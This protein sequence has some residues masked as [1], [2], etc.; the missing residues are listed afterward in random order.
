MKTQCILFLIIFL[1][2]NIAYSISLSQIKNENNNIEVT[3]K[4]TSKYEVEVNSPKPK[5]TN[6]HKENKENIDPK[7]IEISKPITEIQANNFNSNSNSIIKERFIKKPNERIIKKGD[8]VIKEEFVELI[9]PLKINMQNHY[10]SLFRTYSNLYNN[11]ND[12]DISTVC[13]DIGCQNCS[14]SNAKFCKICKHGYF[15]Y[16][17]QCYS[18]CPQNFVANVFKRTCESLNINSK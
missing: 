14:L 2:I 4:Q 18:V 6:C 1:S 17:N 13:S 9:N 12:N 5:T 15:N 11:F 7:H 8:I 3:I 10:P 16:N